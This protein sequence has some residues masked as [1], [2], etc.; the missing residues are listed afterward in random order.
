VANI[1]KE[2]QPHL[3]LLDMD[4]DGPRILALLQERPV[5]GVRLPVIGVAI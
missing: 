2:W 1:L 4:L 3:A 5:G